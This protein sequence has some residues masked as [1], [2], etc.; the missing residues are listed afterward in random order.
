MPAQRSLFR[1]NLAP[2]AVNG[3]Q[4]A[5]MPTAKRAECLSSVADLKGQQRNDMMQICMA[6]GRLDCVKQ[7]VDQKIVGVQRRD[8]IKSCVRD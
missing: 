2:D 6:Q 1:G 8:Y 5:P 4:P 3:A 7:A